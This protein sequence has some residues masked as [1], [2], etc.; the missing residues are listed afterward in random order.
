MLNNYLMAFSIQ[1]VKNAIKNGNDGFFFVH[2]DTANKAINKQIG[3]L[4]K[5]MNMIVLNGLERS[6]VYGE[7]TIRDRMKLIYSKTAREQKKLDQMRIAATEAMRGRTAQSFY[8]EKR[9]GFS[10]SERVWNLAGNAKKEIEIILQN[11]I[12]QGLSAD[13]MQKSLKEYLNKP[14]TL[15]RRVRDKETGELE[16]SKAAQKYKPGRGVYR[17]AYRNALRLAITETSAAYRQAQWEQMQNNELVRGYRIKLSNNHTTL[18]NGNKIDIKDI[19]DELQGVYPKTFKWTGWHP[20]CRCFMEAILVG[21]DEFDKQEL[22]D[23]KAALQGKPRNKYATYSQIKEPPQAFNDWIERNRE[24]A[25]GWQ[26]MP[27]FVRENVQFVKGKFEVGTYTDDELKFTASRKAQVAMQQVLD[28]LKGL[29]P[30]IPNTE[31]AAIHHY[32]R[33]GGNY[34]QLNKQMDNGTLTDFNKA[35][36]GLISKGLEKLPTYQGT[37]YRGMVIKR[38]EFE[39][40]F[41]CDVGSV[42]RQN[43]F[44]SSSKDMNVAFD[45]ATRDKGKLKRTDIQVFFK[46]ESKNGREIGDISEFN[47]IFAP[48]KQNQKEVT[49]TN[50]TPFRIDKKEYSGNVVWVTLTE[51]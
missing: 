21:Q 13:E 20:Q 34:R 51:L 43:R 32:T 45:F 30:E 26:N 24:R 22:D 42:V 6:W 31:L 27:R 10:I 35:S 5:Q 25:K 14:D 50:N 18:R 29:Y 38:T 33:N 1:G 19:C 17:S 49:F 28:K 7:E 9:D 4:A 48:D 47:G 8:N 37:V 41:G 2:N 36:V 46:I 12:K 16:L 39:R 15:F 23:L 44:V 3:T 40:V 11:G